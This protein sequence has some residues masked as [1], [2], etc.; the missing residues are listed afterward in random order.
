MPDGILPPVRVLLV[1]SND[2]T[3][4]VFQTVVEHCFPEWY[5]RSVEVVSTARTD[6]ALELLRESGLF[7]VVTVRRN[8]PYGAAE[9]IGQVRS[10]STEGERGTSSEVPIVMYSASHEPIGIGETLF[11]SSPV[12]PRK[13]VLELSRLLGISPPAPR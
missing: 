6:T 9:L 12:E 10:G 13:L 7:D 8:T 2:D 5:G 1:D 4:T 3:I 11:L